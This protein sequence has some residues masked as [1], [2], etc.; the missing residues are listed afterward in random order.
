MA[1]TPR[2]LDDGTIIYPHRGSTPPPC[3]DGYRRK[4][5]TGP[6][7]WTLIPIWPECIFR[8]QILR[9]RVD[10]NCER[11]SVVCSH[12]DAEIVDITYDTCKGCPWKD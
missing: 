5:E 9:K 3:L 1:R 8:I 10:C 6:D 12:P 7:A 2:I 11:M 4:S